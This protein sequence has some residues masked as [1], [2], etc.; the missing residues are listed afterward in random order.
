[1]KL[2]E[3]V[4]T[5]QG[6]GMHD[7]LEATEKLGTDCG[8][9]GKEILHLRLLAEELFGMAQSI[10]GELE[11]Q[12]WVVQE[13][14]RYEIHL[15]SEVELTKEMHKR[16]IDVSTQGENAAAKGFMGKLRNMIAVALLPK[17]DGASMLSMGLMSMGSPTGMRAENLDYM[18]SMNQYRTAVDH[19]RSA[20]EQA[21][22]AWDEL[23][24]SIVA[25]IADEVNVH[26]KSSQVEI[27]IIKTF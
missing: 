11:G 21:E 9:G 18:W 14:S 15:K 2:D 27:T 25:S 10:A 3:I 22:A 26:I 24:K 23:E 7:A 8:L 17:E 4:I 1:M 20:D 5:N 13:G 6:T 16:F 12:Y 19:N